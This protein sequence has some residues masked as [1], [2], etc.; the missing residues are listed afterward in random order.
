MMEDSISRE[1]AESAK[2]EAEIGSE[3]FIEYSLG[4][5]GGLAR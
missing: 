4:V 3:V 5:L 1:D 2:K